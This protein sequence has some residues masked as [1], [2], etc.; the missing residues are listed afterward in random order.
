MKGKLYFQKYHFNFYELGIIGK[1]VT[2]SVR[3]C[4][5]LNVL[6]SRQESQDVP[7]AV[8]GH[9]YI[10]YSF[11]SLQ[12]YA[13]QPKF[14]FDHVDINTPTQRCHTRDNQMR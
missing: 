11:N 14:D 4:K 2:S 13:R 10:P 1:L 12:I 5:N 6:K 8:L 7:F 3:K 9:I